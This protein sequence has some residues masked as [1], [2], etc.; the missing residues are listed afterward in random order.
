[1]IRDIQEEVIDILATYGGTVRTVN[2]QEQ[3]QV[4]VEFGSMHF[5]DLPGTISFKAKMSDINKVAK[6]K[7]SKA[8]FKKLVEIREY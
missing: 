1:Y 3:V 2:E 7:I 6:D 5:N 4:V 8:E